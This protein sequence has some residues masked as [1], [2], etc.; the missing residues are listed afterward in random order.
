M[1]NN[2]EYNK[3]SEYTCF[4]Y[5]DQLDEK[6][7]DFLDEIIVRKTEDEDSDFN[8]K[9]S[10]VTIKNE[11]S[12]TTK[13]ILEVAISYFN[14]A[15]IDVN[16]NN[17]SILYSSYYYNSKY[18]ASYDRYIDNIT[19]ANEAEKDVHCCIIVTKK[20]EN[21]KGGNIEI[22]NKNPYTFFQL[23]GYE[24]EEK[25]VYQLKTGTVLVLD[26][27]TLYKLQTFKGT[28]YFNFIIVTLRDKNVK[29]DE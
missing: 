1:L 24:Q 14:N 15:G 12:E 3:S 7:I 9:K 18:I 25:E 20:G 11:K 16:E 5:R 27:D 10:F 28:G 23:V 4:S 22:Y 26:G 19:C 13:K 2:K 17:G 6:K 29:E 21:L 8:S